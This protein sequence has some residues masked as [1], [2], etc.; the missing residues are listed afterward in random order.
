MEKSRRDKTKLGLTGL[1]IGTVALSAGML[2]FW[3]GPFEEPLSLEEIV[4]EKAVKIKNSLIAK[5]K[6]DDAVVKEKFSRRWGPDRIVTT[7]TV[8]LGV[9]SILLAAFAFVRREDIRVC[10]VAAV[11]GGGAIAFQFFLLS[12]GILLFVILLAAALAAMGET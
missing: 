5:L 2:H 12:I 1:I 10:G 11:F 6:G 7:G 3:F 8:I 9:T 4:A